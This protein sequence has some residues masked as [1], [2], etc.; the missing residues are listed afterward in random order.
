V[1]H[2]NVPLLR[3]RAMREDIRTGI[4]QL[5]SISRYDSRRS[6]MVGNDDGKECSYIMMDYL[7]KAKTNEEGVV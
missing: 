5:T 2:A 6:H 4:L 1:K 3:V 7:K